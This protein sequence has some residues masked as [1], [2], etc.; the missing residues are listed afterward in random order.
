MY[1]INIEDNRGDNMYKEFEV[2]KF[3]IKTLNDVLISVNECQFNALNYYQE[4]VTKIKNDKTLTLDEK[5]AMIE[6]YLHSVTGVHSLLEE[7]N[8]V[9][10]LINDHIDV[11]KS[12]VDKLITIVDHPVVKKS[13]DEC[14]RNLRTVLDT[15]CGKIFELA[16]ETKYILDEEAYDFSDNRTIVETSLESLYD[17]ADKINNMLQ[18]IVFEDKQSA[19]SIKKLVEKNV[20]TETKRINYISNKATKMMDID[21]DTLLETG[22][23]QE[24]CT[25][26]EEEIRIS[27][28]K[29]AEL[30]DIL[31]DDIDS[32]AFILSIG[33]FI[34]ILEEKIDDL[35]KVLNQLNYI[36]SIYGQA[37][38]EETSDDDSIKDDLVKLIDEET[39]QIILFGHKVSE[40]LEY[41][42]TH[43]SSSK[44][45]VRCLSN[46]YFEEHKRVDEAA[47]KT[48]KSFFNRN[49]L[50][51]EKELDT[52]DY[53]KYCSILNKSFWEARQ[54]ASME[55]IKYPSALYERTVKE[56]QN[57]LLIDNYNVSL[58]DVE[59][60]IEE[61]QEK[62]ADDIYMD[63]I[64]ENALYQLKDETPASV[65]ELCDE[66]YG[67]S[68]L[69]RRAYALLQEDLIKVI[70]EIGIV[71]NEDAEEGSLAISDY[72]KSF[73]I[74]KLVEHKY[75]IERL[76]H[77]I[78]KRSRLLDKST[79]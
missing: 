73:R 29:I 12:N 66:T 3:A 24:L 16:L 2:Y 8:K 60:I 17:L 61:Y 21:Y 46:L 58:E 26:L 32:Q 45:I 49:M 39:K 78:D 70:R 40:T 31:H 69:D 53:K 71:K 65:H 28:D 72:R 27:N 25:D 20:D 54:K 77:I 19:S 75:M 76:L 47:L 30:Q 59:R 36:V 55:N 74:D 43:N 41:L 51:K 79:Q 57:E 44:E 5:D 34:E 68:A 9:I 48:E 15:E 13:L 10:N 23:L 52:I 11:L 42:K 62:Y 38:K 14:T 6:K 50:D 56:Y 18:G 63:K 1:D 64:Y 7:N 33:L 4:K 35:N 22:K 37:S 67:L